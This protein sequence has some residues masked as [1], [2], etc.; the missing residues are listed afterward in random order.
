MGDLCLVA[1]HHSAPGHAVAEDGSGSLSRT[2][3]AATPLPLNR[4]APSAPDAETL[5]SGAGWKESE[6]ALNGKGR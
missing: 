5:T 6:R 2:R 1:G 4:C 3:R